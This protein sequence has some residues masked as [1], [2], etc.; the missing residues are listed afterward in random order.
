MIKL[1]NIEFSYD[2]ETSILEDFDLD[3]SEGEIVAI[4]GK[5]GVGKSTILRLIA[6][7]ETPT[8]GDIYLDNVCI[9]ALPVHKRA[10]GYVFQSNALFP[11]LTV[12]NNIAYGLYNLSKKDT[13]KRIKH[14]TEKLGIEE[15]L[16]RYPH[17]ISGGQQ[18]RVAIAR[19]LVT[20]PKVLLLDE[21]FSALDADLKAQIQ[22]DIK[23]VLHSLN[24]TTIIVTHDINDALALEARIVTM[25]T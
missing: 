6:G 13:E 15:L 8:S 1:S 10:V 9:N 2:S 16:D 23:R 18:Q 14:I 22:F 19:T 3:I 11:H 24:I 12:K 20:Q 21:P 4:Q 25:N 17:E 7:L 5:S